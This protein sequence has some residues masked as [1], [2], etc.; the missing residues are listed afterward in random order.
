MVTRL[1]MVLALAGALALAGCGNKLETRTQGETEGIYI[2]IGELR[3]QVQLSRIINQH[4]VYDRVFLRGLPAGT[5]QPKA[6]E[7]WFGVWLRVQNTTS[8]QTLPAAEDFMIVDTQENEF[9]PVEIDP[10]ENVFAY[11]PVELGPNTIL[12]DPQSPA[13]EGVIQGSLLL[14]KLTNEALQNRPLEFKIQSPENLDEVGI[15][16]LD[17]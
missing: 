4:A 6:D 15:V 16:D 8:E 5:L 17:V 9:E 12:P 3:Y 1:L 14:F 7:A 13:G 10:A 11:A 2:D